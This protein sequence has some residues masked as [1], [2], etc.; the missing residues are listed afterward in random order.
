MT[1]N[2]P[3]WDAS[4]LRRGAT[5]L[6]FAAAVD[7]TI[8]ANEYEAHCHEKGDRSLMTLSHKQRRVRSKLIVIRSGE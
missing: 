2:Q 5:R 8:Y 7:E 6:L 4:P 3:A 1:S